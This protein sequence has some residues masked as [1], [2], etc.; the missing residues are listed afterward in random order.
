LGAFDRDACLAHATACADAS[1]RYGLATEPVAHLWRAGGHALAGD[2][3]AMDLAIADALAKDPDDPRILGDLHGRVL[4]TRA[5]VAGDLD[6]LR[7]H[8]DEM[9]RY[10]DRAPAGTS[11]FPGRGLWATIHATHD[12]DLGVAALDSSRV[13]STLVSMPTTDL[14]TLAVE[15]VALGRQGHHQ[16]AGDLVERV[17]LTRDTITVGSGLRHMQQVLVAIAATRDGWGDPAAWLRESE[18]FFADRGY[19]KAARRCRALIGETGAPVPRRRAQATPV[20]PDLRALGV[21]SRELDVLQLVVE[22][23]STKDIAERL[24]LSP[25]TVERH[26]S[27]LFD[28]TG[29]RNRSDLADIGR[30]HGLAGGSAGMG[31]APGR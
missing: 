2:D 24:F 23:C 18:A 16:Q 13:W 7:T 5:F 29:V 30:E 14:A 17:R 27:N 25:K 19:D 20:P 22:G 9:M 8:L 10:V 12:E 3:A 15:A 21:T 6:A 31:D 1:R 11:V 26:L 4:A 28:R